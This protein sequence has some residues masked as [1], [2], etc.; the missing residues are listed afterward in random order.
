MSTIGIHA[1]NM[2][3]APNSVGAWTGAGEVIGSLGMMLGGLV[4]DPGAAGSGK[5][6][7]PTVSGDGSSATGP[8][9]QG[10]RLL[11]AGLL[12]VGLVF[13]LKKL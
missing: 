2:T 10:S 1:S 12:V 3:A 11:L 13:V 6:G 4:A 5:P 7:S 9:P 8:K